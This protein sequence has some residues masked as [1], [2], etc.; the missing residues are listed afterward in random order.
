M[1]IGISEILRS[2]VHAGS[3]KLCLPVD[4]VVCLLLRR[5]RAAVAWREIFQELH[6][7]SGSRAQRRDA[8][9]GAKHIVEALLFGAVIFAF[10]CD[11]EPEDIAVEPQAGLC[12]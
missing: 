10:P 11:P 6:A 8:Q 7:G 4:Q 3:E 9:A 2:F 12:I 1:V 5:V